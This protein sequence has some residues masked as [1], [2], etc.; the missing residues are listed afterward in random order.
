MRCRDNGGV[1][2]QS[3]L[4]RI[5]GARLDRSGHIADI[6]RNDDQSLTAHAAGQPQFID[7]NLGGLD[8]DI[9]RTDQRCGREGLNDTDTAGL[10]ALLRSEHTGDD[11]RINASDHAGINQPA[12]KASL[13]VIHRGFHIGNAAGEN[14]LILAGAGR[15]SGNQL[16]AGALEGGIRCLDTLCNALQFNDSNSLIHNT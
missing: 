16:D 13:D 2:E 4:L 6:A 14:D 12:V 9:R 3:L 8:G 5:G 7:G 11:L 1:T 10:G 15:M